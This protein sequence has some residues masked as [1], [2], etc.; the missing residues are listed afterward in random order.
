MQSTSSPTL[1]PLDQLRSLNA[2]PRSFKIPLQT[3]SDG[4]LGKSLVNIKITADKMAKDQASARSELDMASLRLKKLTDRILV[5]EAKLQSLNNENARL[6]VK[7][8]EDSK[9]WSSLES[10]LCLSKS[11]F[12]QLTETLQRL[13]Q[14]VEEAE[15]DKKCFENK[16]AASS[17]AFDDLNIKLNS[18]TLKLECAERNIANGKTVLF[19]VQMYVSKK[20]KEK[21]KTPAVSTVLSENVRE[22]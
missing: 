21:K 8:G 22:K 14:Q 12:D 17:V 19:T 13:A 2:T 6:K 7:H 18:L 1:K 15:R 9:L 3:S 11:L 4:M 16:L 5:L 10:K 20:Q